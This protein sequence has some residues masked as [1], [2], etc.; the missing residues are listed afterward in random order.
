MIITDRIIS[1]AGVDVLEEAAL[2]PSNVSQYMGSPNAIR[3]LY[4]FILKK[5]SI[6][7]IDNRKNE[8]IVK[9]VNNNQEALEELKKLLTNILNN[10]AIVQEDFIQLSITSVS[11]IMTPKKYSELH[12]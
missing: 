2:A 10:T 3:T 11:K 6:S 7:V 1:L 12:A 9:I 4:D 5:G 8:Y